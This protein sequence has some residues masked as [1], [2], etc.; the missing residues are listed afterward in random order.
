MSKV[1]ILPHAHIGPCRDPKKE[2]V[3]EKKI[4]IMSVFHV[5]GSEVVQ[6]GLEPMSQFVVLSSAVMQ[7]AWR[8][9]RRLLEQ[10]KQVGTLRIPRI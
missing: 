3:V 4:L 10:E 6:C 8:T 2:K 5:S 7:N 9:G 1:T